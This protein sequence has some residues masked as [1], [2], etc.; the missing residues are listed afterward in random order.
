MSMSF[1]DFD[2]AMMQRA[3]YLAASVG[4]TTSP[5]PKVG[6]VITQ[7]Q[8]IVGEGFHV[9]A[10]GPH[11]EVHALRQAAHLAQGATA[12]VTLEPCSHTGKTPP[13]AN[14]LIQAGVARVVCAMVDPNPQ[15]AGQGL[16][17]LQD[18]GIQAQ[19]G[20]LAIEAAALNRGFLSRIQRKRP[21]VTLKLAASLDG[22]TALANGQSQWITGSKAREDV[23]HLRA[24]SNAI[25]T[26]SGTVILDNPQL[27]V[28]NQIMIKPPVRVVLDRQLK[29]PSHAQIFNTEVAPTILFTRP[30]NNTQAYEDLGVTSLCWQ[31]ENLFEVLEQLA[32]KGINEVWVEAGMT[33]SS[34]FLQQNLVDEL[35]L[36]QA[37]K[38]LGQNAKGLFDF[39]V[40]ADVL[41]Q[42]SVWK[43][44]TVTPIGEDIKWHLRHSQHVGEQGEILI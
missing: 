26:G 1:S 13:C 25:I 6:C 39:N 2:T 38:I 14:A 40:Q 34:A 16:Q 11:A 33:L 4:N 21:F 42:H 23:Q 36:Y 35:I 10:G 31:G 22:K 5:N 18:A 19:A 20:L 15:V 29:S 3:L 30:E 41:Q 24:Q 8:H 28:R 27:T 44:H 32:E 7:G 17:R 37:P 9:I 12:Y 43:T